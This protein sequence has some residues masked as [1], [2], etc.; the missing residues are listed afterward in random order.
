MVGLPF[1]ARPIEVVSDQLLDETKGL[2]ARGTR[3][4]NIKDMVSDKL[5]KPT[6]N[7]SH[8]YMKYIM[9]A[10][11]KFVGKAVD[12]AGYTVVNGVVKCITDSILTDTRSSVSDYWYIYGERLLM[13]MNQ[14]HSLHH[15]PPMKYGSFWKQP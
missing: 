11:T 4:L 15:R 3:C 7:D 5:A 8:R 14:W 10:F 6:F 12:A 9:P 13:I 2:A 1:E